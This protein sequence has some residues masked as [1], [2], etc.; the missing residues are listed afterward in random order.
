MQS[1]WEVIP[2][3]KITTPLFLNILYR[4]LFLKHLSSAL[5]PRR[6]WHIAEFTAM[7]ATGS[8]INHV[9]TEA[10]FIQMRLTD[11]CL[12]GIRV[13]PD[14]GFF[15]SLSCHSAIPAQ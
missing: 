12:C 7:S 6:S 10:F 9:V 3:E 8:D 15:L 2:I 1:L 4:G 11:G 5:I 14:S 13:Y